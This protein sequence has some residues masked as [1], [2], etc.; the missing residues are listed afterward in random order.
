MEGRA[1]QVPVQLMEGR[2][3]Q[4]PVQ[5]ME[6]RAVQ[7]PVQLMEGRAVQVPVQLIELVNNM[8]AQEGK[9]QSLSDML[10]TEVAPKSIAEVKGTFGT[11][12]PAQVMAFGVVISNG[13]K[14][15]M[16]F[17]KS[18]EKVEGD[19]YY[20]TLRYHVL[21]WVKANYPEGNSVW[22]QD[23]QNNLSRLYRFKHMHPDTKRKLYLAYVR[24]ALIYPAI[25][26]HTLSPS[27]ISKLQSVQNKATRFITNAEW[28]DFNTSAQLHRQTKL[29]PIN[30]LLHEHAKKIWTN[31][32]QMHPQLY[33]H[34]TSPQETRQIPHRAFPS[35]KTKILGPPPTPKYT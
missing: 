19:A 21:P 27:S 3:V 2:A 15:S 34:L 29:T 25:P 6:G 13:K 31:I 1:V 24:S 17:Y 7:V 32:E 28:H 8:S 16:Y 20:K 22:T 30:T 23:A 9:R 33:L 26:L 11:E 4:V 5:M 14:M 18:G 35:S 12:H 10:G